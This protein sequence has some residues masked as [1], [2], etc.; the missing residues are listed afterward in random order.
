MDRALI[1]QLVRRKIKDRRLPRGC[2]VCIREMVGDGRPCDA[3]EEPISPGEKLVLAMVPLDW[4]SARL[5]V[6]CCQ[7]WEAERLAV[8]RQHGHRTARGG[9]ICR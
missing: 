6:D 9:N 8:A 3:C 5:H 7:M 2:A 4:M 1:Q